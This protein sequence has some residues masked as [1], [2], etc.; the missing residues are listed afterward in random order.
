M[1]RGSEVTSDIGYFAM[2]PEWVLYA[3]I[4]D[5]AVRLFAVLARH[6]DKRTREAEVYRSTLAKKLGGCS[7]DSVDRAKDELVAIGALTV[8]PQRIDGKVERA[9]NLYVLKFIEPDSALSGVAA[10]VPPPLST[11]ADEWPQDS[12]Q[13][14]RTGAAENESQFNQREPKD[15]ADEDEPIASTEANARKR[16]GEDL[17]PPDIDADTRAAN[18]ERLAAVRAQREG[19]KQAETVELPDKPDVLAEAR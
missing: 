13:G 11:G 4:S 2:L 7:K 5:R 19:I 10:S 16:T 12:D 3:G 17:A 18:L 1:S 9:A 15:F 8:V 14:G 6:A